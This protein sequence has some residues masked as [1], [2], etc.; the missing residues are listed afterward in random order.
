MISITFS[1][2]FYLAASYGITHIVAGR[3]LL[4]PGVNPDHFTLPVS[5]RNGLEDFKTQLRFALIIINSFIFVLAGGGGYF[6]AGKTLKPI[7][8][9]MEKQKRFVT[10]ASHEFRTPLTALKTSI[11]VN[12]QD[13][14]FRS[15][16][17]QDLLQRNLY[18]I[19]KL[20]EL[21]DRLLTLAQYQKGESTYFSSLSLLSLIDEAKVRV[22]SL[23]DAK[24]ITI[25][26]KIEDTQI[27]GEKALLL[28][29]FTILLDNA[30]KYSHKNSAITIRNTLSTNATTIVVH[31][32][33]R[34]IAKKDIPHIFDRFYRADTSRS[35]NNTTGFGL[36]LSIAKQ[37][38]ENHTGNI[39]VVSQ[40]ERGTDFII[41]LPRTS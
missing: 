4:S 25:D 19:D 22:I 31:D 2:A 27:H 18:Q 28:E 10:D 35:T 40:E 8:K 24:H 41:E 1:I 15:L 39:S 14:E 37:I 30:I 38:V 9:S 26:T 36:G 29:L 5:L 33:G 12:M 32:E 21:A 16:V 23:A 34:G 7:E 20:Q 13:K 11:E 6:L 3:Y 17:V